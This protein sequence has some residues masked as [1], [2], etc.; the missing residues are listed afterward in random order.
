MKGHKPP[1]PRGPKPDPRAFFKPPVPQGEIPDPRSLLPPRCPKIDI[2]SPDERERVSYWKRFA[3]A[4]HEET[5][6]AA[7]RVNIA[8]GQLVDIINRLAP[9]PTLQNISKSPQILG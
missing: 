4:D 2:L 1:K 3:F 6:I 5:H 7:H 8:I 9:D